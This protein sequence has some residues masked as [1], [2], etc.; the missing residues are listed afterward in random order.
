MRKEERQNEILELIQQKKRTTVTELSAAVFAS[1]ATIRRDLHA[2][3]QKGLIRLLY[4][5]IVPLNKKSGEMPLSFRANQAREVKRMLARFAAGMIQPNSS[6]LLD[7]S[8]SALYMADYI[9]PEHGITVFTNCIKTAIRLHERG[10]SV[11]LIGGLLASD[12]LI[13]NSSWTIETINTIYADYLFFSAQSLGND[14]SICGA[15]DYGTQI[16][17]CMIQR[18][19][20]QFFLCNSEKVG[21]NCT[22]T[23]CN[24]SEITGVICNT[25][26]SF[27]PNIHCLYVDPYQAENANA[28][29]FHEPRHSKKGV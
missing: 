18:T 27:I 15:S 6:V 25:D 9:N 19:K 26:L 22:F 1:E 23:L 7:S 17:K 5:N 20:Q 16:R 11:Y 12:S 29:P 10:V 28:S 4:G 3:E 24:A 21:S 2:L 14:G 8:S 13:T